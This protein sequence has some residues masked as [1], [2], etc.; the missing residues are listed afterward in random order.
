MMIDW[1]KNRYAN[2]SGR[3]TRSEYVLSIL[4]MVVVF[5]AA[6]LFFNFINSYY[7]KALINSKTMIFFLLIPINAV[8]VRRIRD[9]GYN[10]GLVFLNFIPY[11]NFIFILC[12]L[13]FKGEENRNAYGDSPYIDE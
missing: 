12:L 10:G 13:I 11:I 4:F 1:Y 5:Y 2:F 9:L 8:S 3:A 7:L 6:V